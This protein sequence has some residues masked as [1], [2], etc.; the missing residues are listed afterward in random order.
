MECSAAAVPTKVV[1][2]VGRIAATDLPSH[3]VGRAGGDAKPLTLV[4]D[5]MRDPNDPLA[6]LLGELKDAGAKYESGSSARAVL[7]DAG[8]ILRIFYGAVNA[9]AEIVGALR[10]MVGH[11]VTVR[12]EE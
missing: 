9:R 11:T 7:D 5:R 1:Q 12:G 3:Y 10:G 2:G 8:H 4:K 6:F